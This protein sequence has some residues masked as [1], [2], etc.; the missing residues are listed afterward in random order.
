MEKKIPFSAEA[1]QRVLGSPEGRQLLARLQQ[2]SG[3]LQQAAQAY[4]N[5][6]META[7]SLVQPFADTPEAA[8]LLQKINVK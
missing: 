1:L 7:R 4:Q 2:S 3:V 6:D 8:A 5:G